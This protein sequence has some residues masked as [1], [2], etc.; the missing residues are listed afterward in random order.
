MAI[1]LLTATGGWGCSLIPEVAHQPTVH[2][3]F[4]QLTVIAIC[5]FVNSSA[6]PTVDGRQFALAYF[7]ELQLIPGYE[8]VPV[9]V[10]E[11]EIEALGIGLDNP[12]EVRR[13]GAALGADA[14]VIGLVTDY[15]PFYPPRV[16]MRV[17]WYATNPCFHPI[18]PGYGLPWGTREEEFIPAPL[19]EQA[20]MALARAQMKTQTPPYTAPP[21][22]RRSAPPPG[23]LPAPGPDVMP[24]PPGELS[25]SGQGVR[26][27]SATTV[28]EGAIGPELPPNWPN[29]QGFIPAPPCANP[30]ECNPSDEPVLKHTA[31]YNGQDSSV[32][33]ALASYYFFQDEARLGGWQC[34]LQRSDDFIRFCCRL[35]IY[36]MLSAR[37][38]AGESR[39][40]WRWRTDR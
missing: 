26:Q 9:G 15:S 8:V 33:E 37:G 23:P 7:N 38:G 10:V 18:P 28:A 21:T 2:N 40:V 35:H 19:V 30:G 17:N 14:V 20:E 24:A 22:P 27:A 1:T 32:T 34:Y 3:P 11:K 6:E 5:P 31:A 29:P 13:L 39:V 25:R 36:E 12:D 4:P 16:A